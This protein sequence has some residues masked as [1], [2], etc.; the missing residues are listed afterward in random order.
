MTIRASQKQKFDKYFAPQKPSSTAAARRCEHAGCAIGGE[1]RAPKSRFEP[2]QFHWFCLDHVREYNRKWDYYSGMGYDQIEEEIR[3]DVGWHRPTWDLGQRP[4]P[5]ANSH[6]NG[7]QSLHDPLE[8]FGEKINVNRPS[9][10]PNQTRDEI[11]ALKLFELES[12]FTQIEL[13]KRYRLL[14]KR[15]HPDANGGEKG[16]EENL[17]RII[18]AY[19]LLNQSLHQQ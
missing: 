17:K 3:A 18:A 2:N 14:V 12:N 15:Y 4:S 16:A 19:R 10:R 13:K 6:Q 11:R 8:I 1:F 7:A 9:R 5:M